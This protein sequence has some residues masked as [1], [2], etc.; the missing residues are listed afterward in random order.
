MYI[1]EKDKILERPLGIMQSNTTLTVHSDYQKHEH[2][3]YGCPRTG[4]LK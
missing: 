2:A 4:S 1:N 3:K